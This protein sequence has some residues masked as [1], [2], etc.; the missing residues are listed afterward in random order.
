MTTTETIECL[1]DYGDG[2]CSGAVEYRAALSSTGREFPRCDGHW[3]KR[4]GAQERIERDY[5][6][7]PTPPAW[8]DPEAA[9]ERW[10]DD[11]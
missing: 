1:D 11:Y 10:D 7:S 4:L 9:G 2:E 6:D 3:D 8:F 5:P